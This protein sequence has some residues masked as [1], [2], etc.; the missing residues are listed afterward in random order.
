MQHE[1]RVSRGPDPRSCVVET[2]R[3]SGP[4]APP[5]AS[6]RSR[7]PRRDRRRAPCIGPWSP[8]PA[9]K[10]HGP[11]VSARSEGECCE[12]TGCIAS[13]QE[14]C[15]DGVRRLHVTERTAIPA[16]GCIVAAGVDACPCV[17]VAACRGQGSWRGAGD[18]Q[19]EHGESRRGG[20]NPAAGR[21]S[22]G[23]APTVT[24]CLNRSPTAGVTAGRRA[25]RPGAAGSEEPQVEPAGRGA[26]VFRAGPYC[27]V[28][29]PDSASAASRCLARRTSSDAPAHSAQVY[30]R[31]VPSVPAVAS[32][33]L[34][35]SNAAALREPRDR[36]G[37][38]GGSSR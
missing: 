18:C 25:L 28:G 12:V 33:Q 17:G 35:G 32:I 26:L 38:R 8:K 20:A 30:V 31:I 36:R 14:R 11:V 16:N 2:G 6:H 22:S 3:P 15:G 24:P 9:W 23:H 37:R 1:R 29:A 27:A 21:C 19:R 34:C 10:L 13:G 4:C 7:G 5:R